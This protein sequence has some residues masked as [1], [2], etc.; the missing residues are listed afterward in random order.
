VPWFRLLVARLSPWRA[1]FQTQ[2]SLFVV[3]GGQ[4]STVKCRSGI[5]PSTW[6]SP[7][8]VIQ[9]MLHTH[10]HYLHSHSW[11]KDKRVKAGGLPK[12]WRF[13]WILRIFQ[14][15]THS[16]F[17]MV[18]RVNLNAGDRSGCSVW[19]ACSAALLGLAITGRP[20]RV[21]YKRTFVFWLL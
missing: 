3:C 12:N 8:A 21:G 5:F 18:Q 9:P 10:R 17:F 20:F 13:F 19:G 16:N 6:F 11:K 7:V 2:A 14:E 15:K 4:S 1:V